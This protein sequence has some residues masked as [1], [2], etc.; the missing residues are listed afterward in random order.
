[1]LICSTVSATQIEY[2]PFDNTLNDKGGETTI[3]T[4][5]GYLKW[6]LADKDL[7]NEFE[8]LTYY[9]QDKINWEQITNN[10]NADILQRVYDVNM[11]WVQCTAI[12]IGEYIVLSDHSLQFPYGMSYYRTAKLSILSKENFSVVKEVEFDNSIGLTSY[13][14]GV[15]Y[16]TKYLLFYSEDPRDIPYEPYRTVKEQKTY[17]TT[18][19]ENWYE[20]SVDGTIPITN[21]KT[22]LH[23]KNSLVT[24]EDRLNFYEQRNI[25]PQNVYTFNSNN[26]DKEI[27]YESVDISQ[28]FPLRELYIAIPST[29]EKSLKGK[30]LVSKDGIYFNTVDLP[31]EN[32]NLYMISEV[33][34]DMLLCSINSYEKRYQNFEYAYCNYNELEQLAVDE[35]TY[36]R[37]NDKILGF[38]QPPVIESDR[39][40]VPM[41]FLFEQMGAEVT[42][43]EATQSATASVLTGE[44]TPRS[45]TFA[46]DKT[47][48][49]VN[50]I[51]AVMDVPVRL[52]N[53]QTFVPLRFLSENLGYTVDWDEAANTAI[54]L[55]K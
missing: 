20:Y 14:D 40:L 8:V 6:Q 24:A 32:Q 52:I 10:D 36:V 30:F 45:V 19:F 49:T 55:T 42:W 37:L 25:E 51:T 43:D 29:Y 23:V 35:P 47:T 4:G 48:A 2:T 33:K 26:K 38:S 46:I 44:G 50:G 3:S 16:V 39:T 13:V 53:N 1:M 17:C 54:V 21:G 12:D 15:F 41:R 7:S 5:A 28:I 31:E 18:D 27:V 9:S 11:N 34:N 22:T